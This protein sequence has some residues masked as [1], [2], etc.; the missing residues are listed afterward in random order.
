MQFLGMDPA[1][2]P[3]DLP[4]NQGAPQVGFVGC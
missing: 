4:L 2:G 3:S 1:L